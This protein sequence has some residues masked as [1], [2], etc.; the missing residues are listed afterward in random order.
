MSL[1]PCEASNATRFLATFRCQERVNRL[2]IRLRTTEGEYGDIK[3]FVLAKVSP[4]SAKLTTLRVP[5]LSLHHRQNEDHK[6][7]DEMSNLRFTGSFTMNQ[8]HEWISTCLPE[9]PQKLH[10]DEVN[11]VFEN[12]FV[13]STLC[14]KYRK[15][16][17]SFDSDSISALAILK[18]VITKEATARKVILQMHFE[19][20]E[21]TIVGYL[22]KLRP[23]L[24]E[25]HAIDVQMN[26]IEAIK[27]I[28]MQEPDAKSWM[29]DEYIYILE[30]A[31]TI[32]NKAIASPGAMTYLTGVL[33]DF[34]MDMN[35]FRGI[36]VKLLIPKLHQQLQNYQFESLC[37]F[38]M[39]KVQQS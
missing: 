32:K 5:P 37:A 18:E 9:V 13:G 1:T 20:N 25:L 30:N 3:L 39:Q 23:R 4:A 34:Y 8:I 27:E 12:T 6:I 29:C 35:K 33:T 21:A 26:L 7:P 11:L 38:F 10:Q 2:T 28:E 31:D 22:S 24:D 17:A 19:M 15:G 14:C 36:N 16:E